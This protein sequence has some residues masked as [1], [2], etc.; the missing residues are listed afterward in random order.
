MLPL[1]YA[2]EEIEKSMQAFWESEQ[3]YRFLPDG[4]EVYSIDTPPPTVSGSLHIGHIFSYTQAEIIARFQRM[5]GKNVFYPFGFDD[6]GLPSERLVEKEYGIRAGSLARSEFTKLCRET[7]RR[8]VG[9]FKELWRA[10]GFSVDWDL[11]YETVGPL[12]QKIAQKSF[13]RLAKNGKAYQKETPVLWCTNC[14]TSIAQAELESAEKDSAFHTLPFTAEGEVI[15]VATTRPELLYGCVALFVHPEDMRYRRFV[16]KTAVVPLYDFP[17]PILTDEKVGMEKG[18]G[19]V[20]CATFGDSTDL[21]W[22]HAHNL[23]Y[24]RMVEPDGRISPDVPVAG[25][26]KIK[27]ARAAVVHA[28]AE[29]GLLLNS[30]SIRHPVA[31]H[32][33]CGHEVEILP[34]RQWFI[35]ILSQRERFL[36]AADE[37]NWYPASMK[38]RYTLWVQNLK[39]DWCISRQRFFG[40]PFP[41]WYCKSCGKP[42]FAKEEQLPVNPL[43]AQPESKC[44]CGCKEFLPETA[45]MDTWA[46]SSL[47]PFINAHW[48]EPDERAILPM[49]MRTQAHEIIRTWAFYSIVRSIYETGRVPWKDI[50]ICG[51]VLAKKGEKISKSKGNAADTPKELIARNSADCLRYWAAGAHLGTDT[52]FSQEELRIGGRFLTKLWNAARFTLSQLE[53]YGDEAPETLLPADRWILARCHDAQAKAAEALARY[54]TGSARHE[55]DDLFWKDFCDH[56]LELVKERLYQPKTEDERRS[57]LYALYHAFY[58]ILRLYAVYVPHIT[59]YIYQNYYRPYEGAVSLHLCPFGDEEKAD[60]GMLAFGETLKAVLSAARRYKSEHALARKAALGILRVTASAENLPFLE[61]TASDIR[62]CCVCGRLTFT[63]GAF[64]VEIEE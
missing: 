55:T 15:P 54:D 10:M 45:V 35:D 5:R 24:K 16:G 41:V 37:I 42:L 51:F 29:K 22:F 12:A 9:D 8:Y 53:G 59:E 56:Y 14:R 7:T 61:Q 4:R 58:A 30:E 60:A 57:A 63:E 20:M 43:E 26:L 27:E 28:L 3:I 1:R 64:A 36:A 31:V 40:V 32:E 6:N 46:T 48:G 52:L 13:I 18:T 44:E 2:A 49:G 62:N 38:T 17:I 23:P 39:W 34:S 50:M 11:A 47:S 25:G 33:R 19:A 21:E